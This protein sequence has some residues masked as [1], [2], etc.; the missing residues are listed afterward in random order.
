MGASPCRQLVWVATVKV[1]TVLT[2]F[3]SLDSGFAV[4]E[5]TLPL[6]NKPG[7]PECKN[8]HDTL[9]DLCGYHKLHPFLEV[10]ENVSRGINPEEI[11]ATKVSLLPAKPRNHKCRQKTERA[12]SEECNALPG[13]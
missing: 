13:N 4:I 3:F 12:S 9:H 11:E 8:Y 7:A 10:Q 1:V 2:H 5:P 6:R